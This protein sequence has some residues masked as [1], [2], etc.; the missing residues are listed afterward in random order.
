MSCECE[1]YLCLEAF[2]GCNSEGVQ[3]DIVA[4]ETGNWQGT[5]LFN[6]MPTI[7]EFGVV[8]GDKIV[9]PTQFLNEYYTHEFRV[10][11]SGGTLVNCYELKSIQTLNAG[12]YDPIPPSGNILDG[13]TFTGNG[14]DTQTFT[15]IGDVLEIT[16]GFQVYTQDSFTQTGEQITMDDGVT[17]YGQIVIKWRN[18]L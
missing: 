18:T 15:G 16:I 14:T 7:F 8:S 11:N 10:Y 9:I 4:N 3:L 6:G 17:F 1:Q 12:S 5:I 13:N 2:W